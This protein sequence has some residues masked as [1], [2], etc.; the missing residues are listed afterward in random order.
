LIA[1]YVPQ[2]DAAR[3]HS[4]LANLP[5]EAFFTSLLRRVATDL[6]GRSCYPT[7]DHY[8]EK[9]AHSLEP[10]LI[11]MRYDLAIPNYLRK[12]ASLH[13]PGSTTLGYL[14]TKPSGCRAEIVLEI[15]SRVVSFVFPIR[16]R[17]NYR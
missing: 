1:R 16:N 13:F 14:I 11:S 7:S 17:A 9:Q 10:G 3:P 8:S 15:D 4:S 2:D 12:L 6:T 5:D